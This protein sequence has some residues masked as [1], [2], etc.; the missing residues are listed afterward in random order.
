MEQNLYEVTTKSQ[1]NSLIKKETINITNNGIYYKTSGVVSVIAQENIY[2][3]YEEIAAVEVLKLLMG[4]Q[5]D[6][7]ITSTSGKKL[8]LRHVYKEQAYKA[9]SIINEFREKMKS[10]KFINSNTEKPNITDVADELL[11]L[12]KLK[13]AGILT[14]SEFEI[15]KKKLLG[16]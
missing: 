15:Q 14:Q 4:M 13:D 16:Q 12:S 8:H 1:L 10:N 9:Q 2:I 6:I 11:K 5:Y 3:P 7:I